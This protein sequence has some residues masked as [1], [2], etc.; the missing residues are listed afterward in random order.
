[1]DLTPHQ[2]VGLLQREARFSQAVEPVSGGPCGGPGVPAWCAYAD[3][4][5][6]VCAQGGEYAQ[7]AAQMYATLYGC[8][9]GYGGGSSNSNISCEADGTV[10]EKSGDGSEVCWGINSNGGFGIIL[11]TRDPGTV[12][13]RVATNESKPSE[14][15]FDTEDDCTTATNKVCEGILVK[16]EVHV[17]GSQEIVTVTRYFATE[18]E[19]SGED[20]AGL[21]ITKEE[22]PE[23]PAQQDGSFW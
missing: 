14:G 12:D 15:G 9:H 7:L 4:Q 16:V 22:E 1:M 18:E 10:C 20:G 8:G 21:K 5:D 2:C 11:R 6:G 23:D 13:P 17:G 19:L 3:T